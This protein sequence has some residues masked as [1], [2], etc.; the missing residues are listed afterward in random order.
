LDQRDQKIVEILRAH[1]VIDE[2]QERSLLASHQQWG[3]RA[4]HIAVERGF[5]PEEQVAWALSKALHLPLIKIEQRPPEGAA[6][7]R[8]SV[9]FCREHGVLPIGLRDGGKTLWLVMS[10]PT[11]LAL[12]DQARARARVVRVT[13][14]VAGH[15][16][17]LRAI[18]LYY[19]GSSITTDPRF[20]GGIAIDTG[21][22]QDEFKITDISGKTLVKHEQGVAQLRQELK[23]GPDASGDVFAA[24]PARGVEGFASS[25]F[26]PTTTPM[27]DLTGGAGGEDPAALL[28]RIR[29][30]LEQT[31]AA[32]CY[33]VETCVEQGIFSVEEYR[34]KL[35]S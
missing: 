17:I 16:E 34:Q 22:D 26:A 33:V 3:G 2:M 20:S 15:K 29:A 35:N 19:G 30:G 32:L 27:Q 12:I 24:S 7:E 28:Q 23:Q 21:G 25:S 13:P 4:H 6:L 1:G 18:R 9:E 14:A 10:D 8:L 31:N 11:D 5:A